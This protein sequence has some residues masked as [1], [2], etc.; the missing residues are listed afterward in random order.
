MQSLLPA[1]RFDVFAHNGVQ[2]RR[3][4]YSRANQ[5]GNGYLQ[6]GALGL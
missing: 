1:E 2:R 4:R 6:H 5:N 3:L